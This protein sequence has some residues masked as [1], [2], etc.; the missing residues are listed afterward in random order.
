L[1][2]QTRR[3]LSS[4]KQTPSG[5][6]PNPQPLPSPCRNTPDPPAPPASPSHRTENQPPQPPGHTPPSDCL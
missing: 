3:H 1:P 6:A 4:E 2:E 5:N